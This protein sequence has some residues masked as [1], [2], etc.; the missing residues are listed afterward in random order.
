MILEIDSRHKSQTFCADNMEVMKKIKPKS[1]D[2]AIV[3][4]P[5]FQGPNQ[6]EFYGNEISSTGVCRKYYPKIDK[7]EIPGNDFYNELIRVSKNQIIWGINYFEFAGKV[8]GRIVWDKR[9]DHTD[10]SKCEIASCSTISSVHQIRFMWNGFL[11]GKSILEG[12][13]MQ[14]NKKMNEVRIH[15][16]QK[17]VLLYKWLIETY[18]KPTDSI[19]DTHLGSGS[20]RIAADL[21]GNPFTGI[22]LNR[23]IFLA[24][25][26]RFNTHKN[27]YPL[28]NLEK[29]N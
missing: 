16:T 24:S 26:E 8:A 10:F 19:L 12:S 27:K 1:F 13:V 29:A 28:F 14:G 18:L 11:Q 15:Q 9:N 23:E 25:E 17:P 6:R 5:Y 3:D 20:S 21:T 2:W 22:E 4:P 7:W